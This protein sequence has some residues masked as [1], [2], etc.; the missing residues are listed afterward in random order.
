MTD[1]TPS[2]NRGM[3]KVF[4][5]DYWSAAP[6]TW[7][8]PVQQGVGMIAGDMSG[9]RQAAPVGASA[10]LL[11]REALTETAERF[12]HVRVV[13]DYAVLRQIGRIRH[14]QYVANQGKAYGSMV[15][16]RDCLIEP[17]DFTAVNIYARDGQGITCAM[18]IGE[19][20]DDGH[21]YRALFETAARRFDVPLDSALTCTRLVRAPRHSGRH[22]VDLIRFVRWQT[23]H[24]GWRFCIM[25]TAAKLVPFFTRFEF[26]ETGLWSDDPAAGRLQ[27]LILDTRMQP[28]QPAGGP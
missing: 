24:A 1:D 5:V 15:L 10:P 16:D 11:L 13:R 27:V 18:R 6:A 22:A 7:G 3:W 8:Q 21:P 12:P 28:V 25:Q 2:P 20:G 9:V 23:V 4:G 17:S 14:Q 19:V 26:F